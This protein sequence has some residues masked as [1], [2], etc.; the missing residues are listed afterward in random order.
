VSNGVTIVIALVFGVQDVALLPL[1]FAL[2]SN[3]ALEE[4]DPDTF[5]FFGYRE[6]QGGNDYTAASVTGTFTMAFTDESIAVAS[7][8]GVT[9]ELEDV[10][11]PGTIVGMRTIAE[12]FVSVTAD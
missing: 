7:F 8:E 2:T 4:T 12:G 11:S 1:N 6:N 10:T 3:L 5:V 9:I